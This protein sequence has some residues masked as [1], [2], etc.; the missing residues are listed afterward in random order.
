MEQNRTIDISRQQTLTNN[1]RH[2][3]PTQAHSLFRSKGE[4]MGEV[5]ADNLNENI[6]KVELT[7]DLITGKATKDYVI[8]HFV[9]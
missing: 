5:L 9:K 6:Q 1:G 8:L 4:Y 3:P 2:H 7:K